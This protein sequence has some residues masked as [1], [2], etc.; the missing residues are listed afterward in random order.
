MPSRLAASLAAI[1]AN[2]PATGAPG[3]SAANRRTYSSASCLRATASGDLMAARSAAASSASV[4]SAKGP[5]S[6][7]VVPP[8]WRLNR[9]LNA[10]R[11]SAR[12]IRADCSADRTTWL[13]ASGMLASARAASRCSPTETPTPTVRSSSTSVARAASWLGIGSRQEELGQCDRDVPLVL[14]QYR[15]S[16][17]GDRVGQLGCAEREQRAGPVDGLR[18]RGR[19]LQVGRPQD[20][21]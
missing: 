12:L 10:S 7:G 20:G 8:K 1:M 11:C 13:S 2:T 15:E 6:D 14:Q 4:R 18:D 21:D 19:L 17:P 9:T 16:L 5:G 3:W